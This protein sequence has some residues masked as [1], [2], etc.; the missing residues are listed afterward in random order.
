MENKSLTSVC[1]TS[2]PFI[3]S[4]R[5]LPSSSLVGPTRNPAWTLDFGRHEV[6]AELSNLGEIISSGTW[7]PEITVAGRSLALDSNGVWETICWFSDFDVDYLE[8]EH[9]CANGWRL[10]RQF[11]MARQ[12]LFLYTADAILGPPGATHAIDYRLELPMASELK[13]LTN[14]ASHE[15]GLKGRRALGLVLPIALPEWKRDS[16]VG[17]LDTSS[18]NCTLTHQTQSSTNLYVPCFI[19]L[20][21]R[22]MRKPMTW[23][24]LTVAEDLNIL[25]PDR[26][27]GFRVQ[28]GA[29]TMA[30]VPFAGPGEEPDSLGTEPDHGIPM[31]SILGRWRY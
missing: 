4:G 11:L 6:A 14:D 10:Q 30:D 25:P 27:V 1:R 23:R 20:H 29:R 5:K 19:D 13:F 26:A 12:D 24:Q 31:R 22:R 16:R 17:R 7:Q 9:D 8:I 2:L 3:Q 15:V 28:V 18:G 21:P